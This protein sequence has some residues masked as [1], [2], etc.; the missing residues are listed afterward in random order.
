MKDQ[1]P[2]DDEQSAR[3]HDQQDKGLRDESVRGEGASV[4]SAS[5]DAARDESILPIDL[6]IDEHFEEVNENGKKVRRRGI[7]LLPNLFTTAALFSGFYAIMAAMQ[8]NFEFS[9]LAILAAMI[10]DGL[11]GRVARM[12]NTTSEFGVQYDSLSDMVSFGVAPALVVYSWALVDLG[13]FGVGVAFVYVAGAA[14]RLARFNTQVGEVDKRYFIGLASPAAAAVIAGMVWA[15]FDVDM[16]GRPS[17]VAGIV[18]AL[19]GLLMVS[20]VKY[21]S[22]KELDFRGRVPFFMILL[23]V[24]AFGVV[25]I[26]PPR[27]LLGLFGLYAASG[28]AMWVW[29]LRKKGS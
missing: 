10:F 19:M 29:S 20:N 25:A 15:G 5:D 6:P 18:T 27:I 8:G 11:D 9:A 16:A 24:L 2:K 21:S 26:D 4:D 7:Y 22:F 28:L 17:I 3:P 23:V 14:L 12:T 1:T 13:K